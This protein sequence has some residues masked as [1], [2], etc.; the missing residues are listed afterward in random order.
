MQTP[1]DDFDTAW[2]E[3]VQRYFRDF[4]AFF[5]PAVHRD[6]DWQRGVE[7]L[8]KEL[9]QAVRVA[10]RGRRT[11][12]V[13]AKVWTQAGEETWVLVH[14]EV[15]SQVDKGFA[16]RMY[17]CNSVLSAR[18]KRAIA[19]FGILGD[20]NRNWRPC[21]YSH[22]RWGCRASLVFPVVKLLDFEDCWAKLERSANPFAVVV[23]AHLR[24]QT[25]RR[26]PETRLQ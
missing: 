3:M 26:H 8:D 22:E 9:Q 21:S 20:T 25:T 24:S 18:H 11:V 10:G 23:A 14:V 5:F 15:Q 16:Q 1:R 2:K 12:D 4:V 7:F 13:L 19:S 6:I 17:V